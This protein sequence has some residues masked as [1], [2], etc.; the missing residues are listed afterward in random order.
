MLV[1]EAAGYD[2]VIVETRGRGPER[3]RGGRHDRHVRADA[4][5]QRRRRPA[6]HQEGRDGDRRPGGDQQGRPGP[7]RRHA[8]AGADHVGIAPVRP[9]WQPGAR[10]D[11]ESRACRTW[12][13]EVKRASAAAGDP[14]ECAA[15]AR[16]SMPSGPRSCVSSNCRTPTAA[17]HAPREAGAVLDVGAHRR[18]PQAGPSAST[19]PCASCCPTRLLQVAAGRLPASTAARQLLAAQASR[20]S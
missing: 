19:R 13:P 17:R 9:P 7:R 15:R 5:A 3:D 10:R 1:C 18:G 12:P 6:G 2:V 4:A 8:R 14:V 16:A 20:A 11:A